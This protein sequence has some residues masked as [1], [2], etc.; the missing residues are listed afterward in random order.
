MRKAFYIIIFAIAALAARAGGYTLDDLPNVQVADRTRHLT[1]PDGILSSAAQ[2]RIDSLLADIRQQSTCEVAVVVVND[3]DTDDL[4]TFATDL[5]EKWGI[6]KD[7][8]DNGL[9]WLVVKDQRQ[10]VVRTGYGVEGVLPDG[11][12]G[13]LM[14]RKVYPDF[15][16]GDFEQ[17]V[18][19]GVEEFHRVLTD[20]ANIDELKSERPDRKSEG[21][22]FF[23]VWIAV[24]CV[25]TFACLVWFL[26]VMFGSRRQSDFERYNRLDGLKMPLLFCSFLGLGLPLVAYIPLWLTMRRLRNKPHICYNCGS[27]MQKLDEETD[28]RYLTPAQDAEEH[29][30]SIDYDVWLCPNCNATEVLPYVNKSKSYT[31]CDQCGARACSLESDRVVVNPTSHS[32]GKGLRTYR[33]LNCHNRTQK[34]YDIAKTAPN[35]IIL[36]GGGSG[37]GFGGG[38][39]SGGGF[40]GGHTGGGGFSGGW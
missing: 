33:C 9:L 30:D 15:K 1:N 11:K 35:V 25:M 4:N 24:S 29:L 3:I 21:S 19:K 28:N 26:C 16:R 2:A 37:R 5:F 20:P 22:E 10:G 34:Y 31:V 38:G 6:G 13:S 27:Q 14:R 18:L 39:F 7:D 12:I 40:G 8:R 32:K 17:G 36:P 23:T